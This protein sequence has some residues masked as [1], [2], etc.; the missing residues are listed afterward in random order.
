MRDQLQTA[1]RST[2]GRVQPALPDMAAGISLKAQHVRE[3]MSSRPALG[4]LEI[5]AENYMGAGG[6]PHARLDA[7]QGY[8]LSIH[9]VGLS[10]ASDRPLDRAHLARLKTLCER[11]TP[12]SVSEHLAWAGHS[13]HFYNDLLPVPLTKAMLARVADNLAQLQDTLGRQVLIEN[14]AHYLRFDAHELGAELI[15]ETL[16]LNELIERSGCGLLVDVNNVFVSAHNIGIDPAAWLEAIPASAVGE[17]HLAGHIADERESLLIDNHGAPVSDDVWALYAD[18]IN[19]I[20]SRPTLIEW[21]TQVPAL[22]VLLGQASRAEALMQES[23]VHTASH[24]KAESA[25]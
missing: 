3:L 24:L 18:F 23:R 5:H 21:D 7:L 19:R 2:S 17:I 25:R 12:A 20:G 4:F 16:F 9:G 11:H 14:P 8:P 6:S 10:L 22:E 15:P 13:G 1:G